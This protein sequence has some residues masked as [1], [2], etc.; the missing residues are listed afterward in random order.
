MLIVFFFFL[1]GW[2]GRFRNLQ[3]LLLCGGGSSRSC[4]VIVVV[5]V[6]VVILKR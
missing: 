4:G 5:I 2:L 6:A 1:V 3:T